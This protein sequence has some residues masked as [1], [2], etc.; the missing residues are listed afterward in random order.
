MN[1]NRNIAQVEDV[2]IT[3]TVNHCVLFG[4]YM[5]DVDKQDGLEWIQVQIALFDTR[6]PS[7][8]TPKYI[9]VTILRIR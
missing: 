6:R 7:K 1:I 2:D 5:H 8:S 3:N 4:V 9:F